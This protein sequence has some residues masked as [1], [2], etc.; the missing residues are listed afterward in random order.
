MLAE[1]KPYKHINVR[2]DSVENLRLPSFVHCFNSII[3]EG[4]IPTFDSFTSKYLADNYLRLTRNLKA[5]EVKGLLGRL[6]RVYPSLIREYQLYLILK[7][8]K[9]LKACAAKV[10]RDTEVDK[11]GIDVI[12]E[13]GSRK[14][15]LKIYQGTR[16]SLQ[17]R[18]RKNQSRDHF[19]KDIEPINVVFKPKNGKALN[20][21]WLF[22]E[23]TAT[24]VVDLILKKC[25]TKN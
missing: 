5:D 7:D 9:R 22:R 2:I 24:K 1:S 23:K 20:E 15:G 12:I 17:W 3:D 14:F 13:I 18:K 10:F 8:D 6:S 21:Y 4:E 25:K 11:A 19:P 16:S